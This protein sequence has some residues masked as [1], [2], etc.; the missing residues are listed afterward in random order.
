MVRLVILF[1]VASNTNVRSGRSFCDSPSLLSGMS[2]PQITADL[3]SRRYISQ[4]RSTTLVSAK[5]PT[6]SRGGRQGFQEEF[7][8]WSGIV[9]PLHGLKLTASC[10][11]IHRHR[12]KLLD[13]DNLDKSDKRTNTELAFRVAE[14]S[15]G[16]PVCLQSMKRDGADC[17]VY[18][19]SRICVMWKYRMRDRS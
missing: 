18:W 9:S 5:D 6:I 4:R 19:K 12:P 3:Q 7:C 2:Q 17:S 8:R 15:L 11:L 16:I 14:Q 10:A 1:S 13:W